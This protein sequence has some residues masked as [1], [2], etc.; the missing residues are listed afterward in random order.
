MRII[1]TEPTRPH[2]CG[3]E[4]SRVGKEDVSKFRGL[5]AR[6]ILPNE[7]HFESPIRISVSFHRRSKLPLR[8]RPCGESSSSYA[9]P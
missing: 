1:E 9:V 3:A 5:S 8:R 7:L 4:R 6:G 2:G